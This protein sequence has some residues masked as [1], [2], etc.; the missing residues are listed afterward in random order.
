MSALQAGIS[1]RRRY[2]AA[3]AAATKA[4][5]VGTAFASGAVL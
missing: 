4:F 3:F 2:F 5:K 1:R